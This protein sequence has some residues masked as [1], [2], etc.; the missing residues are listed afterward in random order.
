MYDFHMDKVTTE[1]MKI[2]TL[3][4]YGVSPSP[5]ATSHVDENFIYRF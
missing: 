1:K 3:F 2:L 5:F 4:C